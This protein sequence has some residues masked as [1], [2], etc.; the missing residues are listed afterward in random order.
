MKTSKEVMWLVRQNSRR[1]VPDEQKPSSSKVCYH[2]KCKLYLFDGTSAIMSM[3]INKP[4][5]MRQ[6]KCK[7]KVLA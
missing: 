4:A 3:Q 7:V 1:I 2:E 6:L 5:V